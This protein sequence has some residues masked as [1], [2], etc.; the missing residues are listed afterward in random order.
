MN[1]VVAARS[2]RTAACPGRSDRALCAQ[3]QANIIGERIAEKLKR[4]IGSAVLPEGEGNPGELTDKDGAPPAKDKKRKTM[5]VL[6]KG[7]DAKTLKPKT[8]S[9]GTRDIAVALRENVRILVDA[10]RDAFEDA[11]GAGR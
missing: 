7:R 3:D 8:I 2:M 4:G 6:L 10:M 11:A 1:A 9:I 5:T